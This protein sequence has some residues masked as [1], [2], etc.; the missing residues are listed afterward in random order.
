MGRSGDRM[1]VIIL[2]DEKGKTKLLANIKLTG[3]EEEEWNPR[4][5]ELKF[6]RFEDLDIKSYLLSGEGLDPLPLGQEDTLTIF[7]EKH[8]TP[9][10]PEF[11]QLRET[12]KISPS[13]VAY[14]SSVE[15]K[16]GVA[17]YSTFLSNEVNKLF[18]AKVLRLPQEVDSTAL[19]HLQHEFGIFP[20]I[21]E[22]IGKRIERNYK[23]VTFHTV[24]R[25]PGALLEHYHTLD[26][27]YD[28]FVVHNDL[29][30][31]FLRT[32]TRKP[33]YVIPHGSLIFEPTPKG[34]ARRR[35]N[36]PLDKKVVFCFGFA[37][38]SKGFEEVAKA[39]CKMRDVLFVISG[40]VHGITDWHSKE[41]LKRLEMT[42][43][44]NVIILGKYLTEEQINLYASACDCLLF[45]YKTPGFISSASGALHRVIAAGKP[46]VT[47]VDNRLIELED[48]HHA[49]K[50]Q[51]GDVDQMVYCLT[52]VLKDQDLASRLG[53]NARRFAEQTSWS[54][55]AKMHLDLYNELV[56]EVFDNPEWYDEEYFVGTKGGKAYVAENGSLK[57]WSYYNLTGEWAGA[58][59]AVK[60]L[61]QLFNPKNMLDVGCGRGTFCAHAKGVGIKVVGIDFSEWAINN[62]HPRAKGLIQL[63]DVRDI[64]F[65]DSSFDLVF[66]TDI[67]EHIYEKDLDKVISELQRVSRKWI[68]YNIATTEGEEFVL[69]KGKLPL[70]RWQGTALAGHVNVRSPG[71]WRKKLSN[72]NWI[73]RDDL[74]REFRA[75]VPI[76]VFQNWITILITERIVE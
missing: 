40:A 73:L 52:L 39:A 48:G 23:V 63:G 25:N 61:K 50:Y 27:H 16:C 3:S 47:S 31:K 36:L 72:E 15:E 70:G 65:P 55:I 1:P 5:V 56:E 69:E 66:A 54:K 2:F 42:S 37:A 11:S 49:L 57:R 18:P 68:F 43:P 46:L 45:N 4:R 7:P 17:T 30:K 20:Y 64:K 33:V 75:L 53:G 74:V 62:P 14:I 28:S 60:A 13:H 59:Y 76:H 29:A 6:Q 34:A 8:P 38:E 26:E 12:K 9:K 24:M 10:L 35:L 51:R 19:I 22:L 41:V 71:Y 32:Y 58:E 44:N 67:L 21:D